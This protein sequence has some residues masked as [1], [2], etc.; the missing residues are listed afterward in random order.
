MSYSDALRNAFLCDVV[1]WSRSND[2]VLLARILRSPYSGVPYDIAAAYARVAARTPPLLEAMT[3]Q[4][5]RVS[6][7]ERELVFGFCERVG[8][9]QRAASDGIDDAALR[10]LA[11]RLFDGHANS[12]ASEP[13]IQEFTLGDAV[14]AE[15]GAGVRARQSHFSAS[16]LNAYAECERKWYYRYACGAVEDEGSSASFYGT[17]FHL[18]LEDFHAEFD[19]PSRAFEAEMRK[20]IT[21]YVNWAFARHSNDFD[22]PLEV[23]L[24]KR[25]AQRTAQRYVDWLIAESEK[26]P[27]T[28]VGRESAAS[29]DIGGFAFVGY[30]DRLDRDDATGAVSVIDY[31]TGNIATTGAE[32]RDKVRAFR[33]F[34]LPFYYWAQTAAGDRVTRLALIPLKD[35]LADVR[36]VALEVVALEAP[37]ARGAST[38]SVTEL[39]RARVRMVEICTDL[40]SGAKERFAVAADPSACT[41]CA[42]IDACRERPAAEP[43]RFAR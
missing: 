24:Q 26:R 31:K 18:A 29:L 22:S 32:Y 23:E 7:D 40:T 15:S 13:A 30:I 11:E 37:P 14:S 6:S 10:S 43:Q 20:K 2:D 3:A 17:A 35:A 9:L 33:D 38:I 8:K 21:G 25:R 27:F 42:Y 1:R 12:A 5:L 39:E 28:V 36:P 19:R 34:Q 41:Y 4:R 16:A